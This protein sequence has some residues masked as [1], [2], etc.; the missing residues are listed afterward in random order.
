MGRP[1]DDHGVDGV[2]SVPGRSDHSVVIQ[3]N[4]QANAYLRTKVMSAR[5]EELRLMLLDGAIRFASMGREGLIARNYEQSSTGFSQARAIVLE[6]INTIRPEAD[7][8][9]ADKV[10]GLYTFLF[11]ELVS[12]S[13]ERDADKAQ[14]IIALLEYERETWALLIEQLHGGAERVGA[15]QAAGGPN[16]G[17]GQAGGARAAIS[18]NA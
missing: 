9:L 17:G 3:L 6:L 12:A 16:A 4:A 10:K 14:Q 2:K 11:S 15:V 5:P 8:E 1:G 7:P 13:F 18:V